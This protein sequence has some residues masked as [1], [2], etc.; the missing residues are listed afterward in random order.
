MVW[1]FG[2]EAQ[3]LGDARELDRP[4]S[5]NSAIV[6][7]WLIVPHQ[8]TAWHTQATLQHFDWLTLEWHDITAAS[9]KIR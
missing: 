9:D 7:L 3:Y 5:L 6:W 4:L 8:V 1:S 2:A